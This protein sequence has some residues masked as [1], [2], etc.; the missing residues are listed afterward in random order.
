MVW[1]TSDNST[2]NSGRRRSS[3]AI[4]MWMVFYVYCLGYRW[5]VSFQLNTLLRDI[6]ELLI[7]KRRAGHLLKSLLPRSGPA[8]IITQLRGVLTHAHLS[9]DMK[10]D[11][12]FVKPVWNQRHSSYGVLGHLVNCEKL[13]QVLCMEA[14]LNQQVQPAWALL[15]LLHN[16]YRCVHLK[17]VTA[18]KS[19]PRCTVVTAS[20]RF[21]LS[22]PQISILTN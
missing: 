22:S 10:S 18:L 1:Y 13:Y 15:V 6:N 8:H 11:R 19:S 3:I 20:S 16:C 5:R 12:F 2:N 9:F 14:N 4:F 7:W 21:R 17:T